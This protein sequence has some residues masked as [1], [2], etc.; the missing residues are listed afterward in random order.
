MQARD[1]DGTV[2]QENLHNGT[3]GGREVQASRLAQSP[4]E[5]PSANVYEFT[6]FRDVIEQGPSWRASGTQEAPAQDIP[7]HGAAPPGMGQLLR[8]RSLVCLPRE[9]AGGNAG[10][11]NVA[12]GG[13]NLGSD[14]TSFT[15]ETDETLVSD[16]PWSL[17]VGP[18]LSTCIG[19][20]GRLARVVG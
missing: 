6:L 3:N 10:P 11:S 1:G 16:K 4:V 7:R 17:L 9:Q 12:A 20:G 18:I 14:A 15:G 19:R 13:R 8:S 2:Q 5:T